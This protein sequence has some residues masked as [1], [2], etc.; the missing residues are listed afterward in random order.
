MGLTVGQV[1]RKVQVQIYPSS[2]HSK[3][4]VAAIAV[5]LID[6]DDGDHYYKTTRMI[7]MMMMTMTMMKCHER[8]GRGRAFFPWRPCDID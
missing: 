2:N 6:Y 3:S 8:L 4:T 1:E 7:M 5:L